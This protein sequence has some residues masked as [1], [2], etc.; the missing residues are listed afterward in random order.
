MKKLVTLFAALTATTT[1]AKDADAPKPSEDGKFSG[2]PIV[3]L[4]ANHH[5]GLGDLVDKS[6]F[7]LDRVYLGYAFD[8]KDQIS[9]SVIFDIAS[10]KA[11]GSKLDYVSHVKNA[12]ITWK[13]GGLAINAGLIKTNNFSYQESFWGYR[14]LMKSFKDEYGWAPS[15]DLGISAKYKAA[16]WLDLDISVTNGEGNKRIGA[17]NNY[18]YG[19]GATFKATKGLSFR[20]YY[21]LYTAKGEGVATQTFTTFA[22]YKH[23]LFSIGGEY[24]YRESADNELGLNYSGISLFSTVKIIDKLAIFGRYDY[25]G[26]NVKDAEDSGM[27]LRAGVEY[28]PFKYLKFSP[29]IYNWNPETGKSETY[30]FLSMQLK[31]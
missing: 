28:T 3:T 13:N 30:L 16:S 8:F 7:A 6:G 9:G 12:S 14:Y 26:S 15:A 31:F 2:K 20:A 11:E 29:N 25:V 19:A 17:D 5:T 10:T 1:F 23:S 21:D 22:G 24:L 27:A 4:F 18:R